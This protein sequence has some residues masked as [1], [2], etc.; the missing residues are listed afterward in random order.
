M[1]IDDIKNRF[2]IKFSCIIF[3]NTKK[4]ST[5]KDLLCSVSKALCHGRFFLSVSS[6]RR[7]K[8]SSLTKR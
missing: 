2:R 7:K 3:G 6:D 4:Y 5:L 8:K 1:F